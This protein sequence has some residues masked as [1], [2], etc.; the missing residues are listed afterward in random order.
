MPKD[1]L[2]K[3]KENIEEQKKL[4]HELEMSLVEYQVLSFAYQKGYLGPYQS[5]TRFKDMAEQMGLEYRT[6]SKLLHSAT[7]KAIEMYLER[8]MKSSKKSE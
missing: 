3:L 6:F 5:A 4:E 8:I 1:L 7:K 2:E